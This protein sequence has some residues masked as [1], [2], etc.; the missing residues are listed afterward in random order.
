M[1]G[2]STLAHTFISLL[3]KLRPRGKGTVSPWSHVRRKVET[4]ART[5]DSVQCSHPCNGS[6]VLRRSKGWLEEGASVSG[7]GG[8]GWPNSWRKQPKP[9][10]DKPLHLARATSTC[11]HGHDD[12]FPTPWLLGC[13]K[14]GSLPNPWGSMWPGALGSP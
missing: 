4:K 1:K 3:G 9:H 8:P 5:P 2:K 11:Q 13:S 12:Q 6:F 10:L 7:S 14:Q